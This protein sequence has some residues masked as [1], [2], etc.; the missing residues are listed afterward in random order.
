MQS[1][2]STCVGDSTSRHR[3]SLLN[4][5]SIKVP[6]VILT[7]LYPSVF[8]FF[9]KAFL[10]LCW[11]F[12]TALMLFSLVVASRSFSGCGAQALHI[13]ASVVAARWTRELR[14]L[15]ASAQAQ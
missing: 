2:H 5:S 11:V 15:G 1:V 7:S 14:L 12:V 9:F 6:L 8:L 13:R 10:G 4:K 3:F